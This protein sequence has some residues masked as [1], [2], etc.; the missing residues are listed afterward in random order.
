MCVFC[1]DCVLVD[2]NG[3]F[4][5]VTKCWCRNDFS[6]FA[7]CGVSVGVFWLQVYLFVVLML[8]VRVGF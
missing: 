5:V 1:V 2:D 3:C 4:V 6:C 8:L 7:C